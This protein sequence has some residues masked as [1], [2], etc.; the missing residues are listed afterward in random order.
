ME[1]RGRKKK[2]RTLNPYIF[3]LYK[4]CEDMTEFRLD[5]MKDNVN[6]EE[7]IDDW[8]MLQSDT[9]AARDLVS[10]NDE[11]IDDFEEGMNETDETCENDEKDEK[12]EK[13]PDEVFE[14]E[15]DDDDFS[16]ITVNVNVKNKPKCRRSNEAF[17]LYEC[18]HASA[19]RK[20]TRMRH[21]IRRQDRDAKDAYRRGFENGEDNYIY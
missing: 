10:G 2:L 4:V 18:S 21:K 3:F 1:R 19:Y 6:V 8:M 20:Q 7:L 13:E 9:E 15:N 5:N 17:S 14:E 12:D 16:D 11:H